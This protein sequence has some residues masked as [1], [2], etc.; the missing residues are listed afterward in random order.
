MALFIGRKIEEGTRIWLEQ[1]RVDYEDRAL[2]EIDLLKPNTS[3]FQSISGIKKQWVCTSQWAVQWFVQHSH[4]IGFKDHEI[5][6]CLSKKQ[7]GLLAKAGI[8]AIVSKENNVECLSKLLRESKNEGIS[9][10]LKGDRSARLHVAQVQETLVYRNRLLKPSLKK[11]FDAYVFFSPSG[12]ASFIE[13]G[14]VISEKAE[15]FVIGQ[16]TGKRAEKKFRNTVR[17]SDKQKEL[18]VVK[19]AAALV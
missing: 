1:H 15:I 4:K 11:E 18:D 10:Y 3:F 14:N 16:T 19:F 12:I 8:S 2:I 7:A 17:I 9:I 6:Y 5:V 13:G